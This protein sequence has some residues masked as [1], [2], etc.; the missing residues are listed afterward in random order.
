MA[1]RRKYNKKPNKKKPYKKKRFNRRKLP[2]TRQPSAYGDMGFIPRTKVV[3]LPYA[4]MKFSLESS[5]TGIPD[6]RVF[7]LNSLFDPDVTG[8]GHQPMGFDQWKTFY[9]YYKVL[10]TRIRAKF[11]WAA[12]ASVGQAHQ[13]GVVFLPV[14]TATLYVDPIILT[15]MTYGRN[16]KLLKSNTRESA[17]ITTNWSGKKYFGRDFSDGTH[18][19]AVTVNPLHYAR[20]QVYAYA[21]DASI[22][23]STVECEV[24]LE[25]IVQFMHPAPAVT[26]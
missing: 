23:T 5:N 7:N 19:T 3:K 13:V 26:S 9:N 11:Y 15:E 17:T 6:S 25:Y 4:S 21:T 12:A 2:I 22:S 14:D 10:G 24:Y 1:F 8:T 16:Y 20:A 18:E